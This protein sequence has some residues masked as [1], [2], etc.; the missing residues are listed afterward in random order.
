ME[1][2]CRPY[3]RNE[4]RLLEFICLSVVFVININAY[5]SKIFLLV[6][7]IVAIVLFAVFNLARVKETKSIVRMLFY[8]PILVAYVPFFLNK[9]IAA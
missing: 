6:C 1:E 4:S 3:N 2:K 9:S 8:I 5:T 7:F